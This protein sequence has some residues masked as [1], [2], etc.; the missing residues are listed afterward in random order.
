MDPE[1][2]ERRRQ[3]AAHEHAAE[4]RRDLAAIS[5]RMKEED[6]ELRRKRAAA[7]GSESAGEYGLDRRVGVEPDPIQS[8]D[9]KG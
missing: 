2:F 6:A 9:A 1:A 3:A 4:V 7:R 5:A 8:T